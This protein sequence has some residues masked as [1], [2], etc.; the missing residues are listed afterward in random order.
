M[1]INFGEFDTTTATPIDYGTLRAALGAV[2]A[3][4][5][6]AALAPIADGEVEVLP[7]SSTEHAIILFRQEQGWQQ[8]PVA[9][10]GNFHAGAATH[11]M[12]KAL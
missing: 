1:K 9:M 7:P 5:P 2:Q 3:A 6:T 11:L 12:A 8:S 10:H 4:S